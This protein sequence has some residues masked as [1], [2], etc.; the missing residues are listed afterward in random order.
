MIS[1][2][3]RNTHFLLAISISLFLIIASISGVILGI[4]ALI[5]QTKPQAIY[6]LKSQSL[7]A[8]MEA[9][10]DQFENVYEIVVTEKKFVV[11]QGI[12][13]NGFETF[14]VDPITGIKIK[15]VSPSN[16]FFNH[17]RSLHRSLFL[18]KTGRILVG[19]VAFLLFLLSI[20][21]MILLVKRL[22][23]VMHFFLPLKENNKYRKVHITLG[24][25]F[26]IPL[27]I[28]GISGA[29]LVIERFDGFSKK[30]SKIKKYDAGEKK[31]NLNTLYL[32]DI[33]RVSYPFS[34][35]KNDTYTIELKNRRVIIRQGDLSIV[36]DEIFHVHQ[37]LKNWSY[38]IHTGDTMVVG[39]NFE[40]VIEIYDCKVRNNVDIYKTKN[41]KLTEFRY[42]TINVIK[43]PGFETNEDLT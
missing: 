13:S 28:I 10:E 42:R 17:V 2:I 7:K 36:N 20:T 5:D 6:S 14:Y 21:G 19:I 15:N 1:R 22:G 43:V 35:L 12:T 31:L 25:W 32:S 9:L 38:Y 34:N 39:F 41:I 26:F 3:W 8:T 4:E 24:K 27:L 18:K 11:V 29:Y 40:D 37:I 16:P 23:G 30:E 33:K